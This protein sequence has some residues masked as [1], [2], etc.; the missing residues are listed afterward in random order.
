MD[1]HEFFENIKEK[2]SSFIE[3]IKEYCAENKR[4][5]ILF[6]ALFICIIFLFILIICLSSSKKQKTEPEKSIVLTQ[7]LLVPDGPELHKD[8]NISRETKDKWSD[9]EAEKWFEIPTSKDINSLE[10]ANDSIINDILGAA[11]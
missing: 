4:N 6:A 5:A 1:M 7:E 2:F 11:P 10:K 8:Y 9:S 3:W